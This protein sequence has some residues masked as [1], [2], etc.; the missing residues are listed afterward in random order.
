MSRDFA[1]QSEC[2][3]AALTSSGINRV[4]DDR[5][6]CNGFY[7]QWINLGFSFQIRVNVVRLGKHIKF[8]IGYLFKDEETNGLRT[9]SY[10]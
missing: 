3:I 7:D 9:E 8:Q 6:V 1:D 5:W 2:V 10:F 4:S